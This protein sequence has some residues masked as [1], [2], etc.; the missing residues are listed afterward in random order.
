MKRAQNTNPFPKACDQSALKL[1]ACVFIKLSEHNPT[2]SVKLLL[3]L[4]VC[5][6]VRACMC[7]GKW[8][9][10]WRRAGHACTEEVLMKAGLSSVNK[11]LRIL[12]FLF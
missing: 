7:V 10:G 9:D 1:H 4:F 8:M 2:R 6:G 5:V 3:L 11:S 12:F